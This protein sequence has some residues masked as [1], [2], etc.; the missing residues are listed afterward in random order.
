MRGLVLSAA[1]SAAELHEAL[2]PPTALFLLLEGAPRRVGRE[3]LLS[4]VS[5]RGGVTV[6]RFS[7]TLRTPLA[8][9]ALLC[10]EAE[11][12]GDGFL[13]LS[14]A[15]LSPLLAR[16]GV[17][18]ARTLLARHGPVLPAGAV[19]RVGDRSGRR[20]PT[21]LGLVL[22][23]LDASRFGGESAALAREKAAFRTVMALA[24]RDEGVAAFRGR[25]PPRFDW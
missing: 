7:G 5:R 1:T 14:G 10:D 25:R 17:R 16:A 11:W 13:D 6:A 8:E 19:L 23:L 3:E 21:A 24:D 9:V 4:E 2:R 20:S 22:G 12:E 18:P 15:L